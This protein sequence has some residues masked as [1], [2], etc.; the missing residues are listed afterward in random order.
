MKEELKYRVN[1][2]SNEIIEPEEIFFDPPNI[3]IDSLG[4]VEVSVKRLNIAIF[5]IIAA[6]SIIVLSGQASY[7]QIFKYSYFSK[8]SEANRI[9]TVVL[10]ASRG[11]IFDRNGR[12][13]VFNEPAFDV[14]IIPAFFPGNSTERSQVIDN[15]ASILKES[16]NDIVSLI[17]E[18]GYSYSSE[19]VV[20]EIFDR[21][22]ILLLK[23]QIDEM[24][25]VYLIQKSFRKYVD[26]EYFAH[27]IG[28]TGK[29][30]PEELIANPD[31]SMNEIV[32]KSGIEFYYEKDLKGIGGEE[33]F[34][35]DRYRQ[36]GGLVAVK[37]PASGDNILL[38]I[39]YD[40][41]KELYTVLSK[42]LKY[43]NLKRAA[44]VIMDPRNGEILALIS[45]P[46]FDNNTFS[47]GLNRGDP[48]DIF[49]DP[50]KPLFNRSIAGTYPPGSTIKPLMGTAILEEKI[51]SSRSKV[52]APNAIYIANQY[53]S[54]AIYTFRDWK[55][56]GWI[57]I[58]DALAFSS[59]VYFYKLGGGYQDIDGLGINKIMAYLERFNF[60]SVL[61]I[62]IPGETSGLLPNPE[63][64]EK[65]K[66]EEWYTGDTYNISIG[67]GDILVTP[68]QLTS[69][70]SY[71]ANT[72]GKW[73]KPHLVKEIINTGKVQEASLTKIRERF[74]DQKNTDIIKEGM[75]KAVTH[76]S[77][78]ALSSLAIPVAGKTGTAQFGNNGQSHA[79]FTG[80]APFA[81]PEIVITI[82]IEGG[83]EG[84]G[85]AVPVAKEV[86]EW[87]FNNLKSKI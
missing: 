35:F 17:L 83:G 77:A 74:T 49:N 47:K 25:G 6:I 30:D 52:L 43:L 46:S 57:D 58:I 59:N 67:Q 5:F 68:L 82:L 63:W 27:V 86:L 51:I 33:K 54:N 23:S 65:T 75:R 66:N 20:K 38:T 71:L 10:E 78:N 8:I 45:L 7:L 87:Y 80:F 56:H 50:E 19:I 64:K 73:Y 14:V 15:L 26:G 72:A 76:G 12:Q 44:G 29:I 13:L 69:A 55:N 16:S 31:Y 70:I 61:G 32:G 41:Q 84:S 37:N 42:Q 24:K 85:A 36:K 28:Y 11:I 22:S 34:E 53:N 62:D 3:T 1:L 81:N 18:K 9:K 48:R 79:W 39:D 21:E 4:Q 60:G 2:Q 40:L